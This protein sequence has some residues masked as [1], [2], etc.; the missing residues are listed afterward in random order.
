[1]VDVDALRR[2]ADLVAVVGAN[3]ELVRKGAEFVGLCPFHSERSPSFTVVP[4]K[5]YVHCFGCG[6]HHDVIG[7]V[8]RMR[9]LSFVDACAALGS[10]DSLAPVARPVRPAR[11]DLP[12]GGVWVQILPVAEDA[13]V[14]LP[15][16]EGRLWNPKRGR[17]W[18]VMPTRA[19]AYHD[20][21]GRLLGYVLR[22]DFDNGEKVTPTATWCMG[23]DGTMRWCCK[24]WPRPRP[25]CGLDALAARPAAP[26]L[27]V[28]GEKCRAA[29]AGAF[30][31]YVCMTWPGG[32]N[33]LRFADWSPLAGRDVVLWPDADAAGRKAM[34]GHEHY[35]G[36]LVPGA[37]QF[38]ARAGAA[39]LRMVDSEGMPPGWDIAD[40][41]ADGWTPRQ[42]A[43]WA[44][45]RVVGVD[46]R[47]DAG[48][49][50][51]A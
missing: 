45:A 2:N 1:M 50:R 30:G 27:M 16:V 26:V 29:G 22:V 18:K 24:P 4:A 43:G 49:L 51:A 31:M 47:R 34:L 44:A 20:A 33:G 40:A 48:R 35:D 8:M 9:E 14:F 23:P 3:V 19:D 39:S 32:S 15:G 10:V 5:G 41:V 38:L 37:A 13:P 12:R 7:Y 28:E 21:E 17:W 42:I 36:R 11:E 25:L 46:V 6:A